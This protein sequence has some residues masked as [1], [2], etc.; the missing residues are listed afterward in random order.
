MSVSCECCVS[1]CLCVRL[2]P[3][4]CEVPECDRD[5]AIMRRSWP[6]RGCRTTKRT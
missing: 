5:A 4:E 3:T 2:S 1:S 6:T